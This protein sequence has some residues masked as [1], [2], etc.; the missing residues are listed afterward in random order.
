YTASANYQVEG[1]QTGIRTEFN[2]ELIYRNGEMATYVYYYDS[3][4][5]HIQ[6]E[7]QVPQ[8]G[9][10]ARQRISTRYK[11]NLSNVQHEVKTSHERFAN[12]GLDSLNILTKTYEYDHGDRILS[13]KE[14]AIIGVK[15]KTAT[16]IAYRYN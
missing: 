1:Y 12:A 5:R 3:N 4:Y 6:A 14:R 16:T 10:Y 9:P 11:Y 7:E 2:G 8:M 15:D 13:V